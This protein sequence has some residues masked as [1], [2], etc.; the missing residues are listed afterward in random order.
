MQASAKHILSL[1]V[2]LG[3][4][5]LLW[6]QTSTSTLPAAKELID[7]RFCRMTMRDMLR[8]LGEQF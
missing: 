4:A 2:I 8:Y 3:V 5:P 6:G 7:R 1:V